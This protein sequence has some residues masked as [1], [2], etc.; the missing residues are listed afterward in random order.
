VPAVVAC[1]VAGIGVPMA[2][3]L[4]WADLKVRRELGRQARLGVPAAPVR[5]KRIRRRYQKL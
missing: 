5:R 2:L 3:V 1:L 4:L